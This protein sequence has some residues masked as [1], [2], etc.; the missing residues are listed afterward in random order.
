M[1]QVWDSK[2]S[3]QQICE[4]IVYRLTSII[5]SNDSSV[6]HWS[7]FDNSVSPHGL[8]LLE[9]VKQLLPECSSASLVI[10][11]IYM[12]RFSRDAAKLFQPGFCLNVQ[13]IFGLFSICNLLATKFIDDDHESNETL[14]YTYGI[15]LYHLNALEKYLCE[16]MQWNYYVSEMEYDHTLS[17]LFDF[18][19]I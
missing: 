5:V 15:P 13:N 9:F 14:S 16:I 17:Q 3:D 2:Y 6:H 18:F 11:Y 1:T 19:L 4:A 10:T 7:P 8:S 12:N